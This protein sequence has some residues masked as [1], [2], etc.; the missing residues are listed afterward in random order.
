MNIDLIVN[1][2]RVRIMVE[3]KQHHIGQFDTLEE[4][5]IAAI[6]ARQKLL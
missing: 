3:G 6:K 4:A 1:K 5:E 2:Y